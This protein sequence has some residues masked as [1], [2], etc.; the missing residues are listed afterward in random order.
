MLRRPGIGLLVADARSVA[1]EKELARIKASTWWRMTAPGRAVVDRFKNRSDR[2]KSDKRAKQQAAAL[3]A[4][5]LAE[6]GDKGEALR[7]RLKTVLAQYKVEHS[8]ERDLDSTIQAVRELLAENVAENELLWLLHIAFLGEVPNEAALQRLKADV[9]FGDAAALVDDLFEQWQRAPSSWSL[10]APM[11]LVTVPTVDVTFT[12][13]SRLRTGIQ[14]VVREVVPRWKAENDLELII[15][16]YGAKVWRRPTNIESGNVLLWSKWPRNESPQDGVVDYTIVVP[17]RTVVVLVEFVAEAAR[18]ERLRALPHWSG[19]RVSLTYYDLIPIALPAMVPAQSVADSAQFLSVTRVAHRVSAIS[20]YVAAELTN[21]CNALN[22]YCAKQPDI[23]AQPIPVSAREVAPEKAAAAAAKYAITSEL[24]TVL[25]VS[26]TEPRKNHLRLLQAAEILWRE[27]N[28]FQL[29]LF[30]ASTWDSAEFE[31]ELKILLDQGRPVLNV[32]KASETD[33]WS[34]YRLARFTVF[35]SLAEGFGLPAAESLAA[36]TPVVLSNHGSM[37]EIGQAGGVEFV[38]ARSVEA[39]A[40]GMRDLLVNDTHLAQLKE[41]I[42][43]RVD[44]KWDDYA[45]DSWEWLHG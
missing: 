34:V 2:S 12:A 29:L 33:L 43:G 25:C 1:A 38:D 31:R 21:I 3:E 11:R 14:R 41:Q 4:L 28:Q 42:A 32:F 26:S 16:D 24:P 15:F 5:H 36:G 23:K 22:A 17:W 10:V 37:V 40:A 13:S 6:T 19:S 44:T 20:G 30:G 35:V 9:F 18:I 7:G 8:S 27:G 45:R 39:I